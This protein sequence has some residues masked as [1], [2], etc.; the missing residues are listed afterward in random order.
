MLSNINRYK[1]YKLILTVILYGLNIY[2]LISVN[3][4]KDSSCSHEKS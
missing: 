3:I 4:S 1:Q 2:W